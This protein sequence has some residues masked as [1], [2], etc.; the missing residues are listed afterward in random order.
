VDKRLREETYDRLGDGLT[1]G[2]DLGSVSTTCDAH[3][4]I[5][6][7]YMRCEPNVPLYYDRS[8]SI[9]NLSRPRMRTGS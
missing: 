8:A 5:D 4:D 7:C 2:V 1:D 9:P 6:I 3:A